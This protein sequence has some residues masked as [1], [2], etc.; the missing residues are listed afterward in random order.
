MATR[1]ELAENTMAHLLPPSFVERVA[2]PGV[3]LAAGRRSAWVVEVRE[4]AVHWVREELR[5]REIPSVQWWLGWSTP[6]AVHDELREAGLRPA[7]PPSL[8]AMTCVV[9]PPEVPGSDVRRIA[10][11]QDYLDAVDIDW[12]A[13]D[14]PAGERAQRRAAEAERF[15]ENEAAGV[16]HHFAAYVDDRPVGFGRVIDADGGAALMG[17]S[18][19]PAFRGRGVY[20]ALIR[21]RWEH[22]AARGAPLL[23]VQAGA[24]SAP[25]LAA[26]DFEAHGEVMLLEELL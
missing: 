19:L 14:V 8:T 26:L 21:A 5:R 9:E 20:R 6:A 7:D 10:T 12:E 4:A 23:A 24:M 16:V 11:A 17:G 13:W 15:L 2:G 3:T 18:V 1:A 25:I 22:T